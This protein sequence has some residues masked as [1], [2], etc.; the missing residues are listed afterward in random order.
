MLV[1]K[2]VES[3][4]QPIHQLPRPINPRAEI[5]IVA[6]EFQHPAPRPGDV[7][8]RHHS[9]LPLERLQFGFGLLA[10]TAP[11]GKFLGQVAEHPFQFMQRSDIRPNVW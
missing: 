3:V 2:E 11:R 8:S 7:V 10:S 6:L 1:L 9:T 5:E 4:L